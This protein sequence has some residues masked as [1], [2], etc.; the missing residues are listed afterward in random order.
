MLSKRQVCLASDLAFLVFLGGGCVA[1]SLYPHNAQAYAAALGLLV[2]T[3]KAAVIHPTGTGK[4][5]IGFKLCEDFPDA[6]ICWLSRWLY[7]QLGRL[8]GKGKPLTEDQKKQLAALG[9]QPGAKA[10]GTP[11]KKAAHR[12]LQIPAESRVG[13]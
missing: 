8:N 1:I 4:S 12:T 10:P 2:E 13:A 3:R 7:T 9:I 6:V 11:G 5:F